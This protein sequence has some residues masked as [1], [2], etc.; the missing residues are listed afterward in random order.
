MAKLHERKPKAIQ[1]VDKL[2]SIKQFRSSNHREY[3]IK[4]A[5]TRYKLKVKSNP[6]QQSQRLHLN[7]RN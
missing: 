4:E 3:T 5:Q 2:E 7:P 6:I 1:L